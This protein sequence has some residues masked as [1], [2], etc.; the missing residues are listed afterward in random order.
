MGKIVSINVGTP[1]EVEFRGRKVSTAIYKETVVG[2]VRVAGVNL[3]GDDQA[4]RRNHGGTHKAIYA[5]AAEDY[6]WWSAGHLAARHSSPGTFG[7]NLTT[8]GVDV[9]GA[10]IGQQWKIGEVVLEVSEPRIPCFKLGIRMD[11]PRFPIEFARADR[12]GA[13]LRII[14]EGEIVAGASVEVG[15]PPSHGLTVGDIARIYHRD[16]GAAGRLLTVPHLADS[17]KDWALRVSA[18]QS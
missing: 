6:E 9:T 2:A 17:W 5:Y 1:R 12:P 10:V 16:Q 11:D 7:D 15:K 3:D 18:K 14:T 13:Y 4:D 8:S